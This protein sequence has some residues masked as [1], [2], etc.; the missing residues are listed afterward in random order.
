MDTFKQVTEKH[1]AGVPLGI[2]ELLWK[3]CLELRANEDTRSRYQKQASYDIAKAMGMN[4]RT[5]EGC[6]Y[7][8]ARREKRASQGSQGGVGSQGTEGLQG[9][10]G[11]QGS[12]GS[13]GVGWQGMQ[14]WQV[15][16]EDGNV[17]DWESQVT[18]FHTSYHTIFH[19][20]YFLRIGMIGTIQRNGHTHV[21]L[22]G[23]RAQQ[24]R[25]VKERNMTKIVI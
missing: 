25:R 1:Y 10:V 23:A 2:R 8:M 20:P 14:G 21:H 15:P 17:R 7:N 18:L 11:W 3:R 24:R 19:T 22:K 5:L 4:S 13:Q 16:T 12:V 9:G 6:A